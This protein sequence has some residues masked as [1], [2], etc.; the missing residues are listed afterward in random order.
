MEQQSSFWVFYIHFDHEERMHHLI[1]FQA[2][3]I[4]QILLDGVCRVCE[5][6]K[7]IT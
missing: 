7:K 4:S 5:F 1:E 3:S 2:T 6:C